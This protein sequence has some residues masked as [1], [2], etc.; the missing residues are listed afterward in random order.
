MIDKLILKIAEYIASNVNSTT[1]LKYE[2]QALIISAVA[3]PFM[4]YFPVVGVLVVTGATSLVMDYLYA[5]SAEDAAAESSS[6][7]ESDQ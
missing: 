6:E 2:L 4:G 7:N 3:M 1:L 5:K